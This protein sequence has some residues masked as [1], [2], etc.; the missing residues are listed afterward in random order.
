MTTFTRDP[1]AVLD[2]STEWSKWLVD[3]KIQTRRKTA[4]SSQASIRLAQNIEIAEFKR[5]QMGEVVS[6]C[7]HA[8]NGA[9]RPG[10]PPSWDAICANSKS[11]LRNRA[12]FLAS[13]RDRLICAAES[14][15]YGYYL[16][17]PPASC[18][19][20]FICLGCL[21]VFI[22]QQFS[23]SCGFPGN[24]HDCCIEDWCGSVHR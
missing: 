16:F 2:Y 19:V 11:L 10:S 17:V 12:E 13:R 9:T 1:D 24:W 14:D 23:A 8:F 15:P 3:D 6:C 20:C 22:L 18:G 21:N 5:L 7:R 4:D